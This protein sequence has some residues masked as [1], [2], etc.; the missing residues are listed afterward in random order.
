MGVDWGGGDAS[1]S[2]VLWVQGPLVSPVEVVGFTMRPLVV[3]QGAY[4]VF[5]ALYFGRIGASKMADHAVAKEIAYREQFKG[6]RVRGRFADMAGAQQRNDWHEHTPPLRTQWYISRDFDPQVETV[7]QL[8][9][10]NLLYMDIVNAGELVDDVEAWRQEKGKEVHDD[11]S[12]GPA[13]LRYDL[14]NVTVIERRADNASEG[15]KLMPVIRE[16]AVDVV[17][18]AGLFGAVGS[19]G[20]SS[21]Q[22]EN[23][24]KTIGMFTENSGSDG[25]RI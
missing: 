3:P 22:T 7:Q 20:Q 10:D 23:W 13:A 25:W 18:R 9:G 17:D 2:V 12:H 14:G 6:W 8:V 24:R 21:A 19:Q 16:R 4:V 11:S 1:L 15:Q 5:N